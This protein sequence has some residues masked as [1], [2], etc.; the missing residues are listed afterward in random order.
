MQAAL[1]EQFADAGVTSVKLDG[2]TFYLFGQVWARPLPEEDVAGALER[3]GL[4]DLVKR[5]VSTQALSAWVREY[6]KDGSELPPPLAAA[7]AVRKEWQV[8]V[9]KAD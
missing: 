8:R 7:I 2:R 4:A 1:L 6:T 9:R 5:T 3:C